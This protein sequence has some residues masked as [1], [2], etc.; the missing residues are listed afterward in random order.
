MGFYLLLMLFAG[1]FLFW[2][3]LNNP[4]AK[5]AAVLTTA[6]PFILMVVG[7]L[8]TFFRRS[9]SSADFF[10]AW[11]DRNAFDFSGSFLVAPQSFNAAGR[12]LWR[13]KIHSPLGRP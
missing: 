8:L 10:P 11:D 13:A 5:S 6:G 7:A 2:F 9:G 1:L 12:L 3:V 4:A